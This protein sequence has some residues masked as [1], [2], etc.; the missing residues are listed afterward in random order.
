MVLRPGRRTPIWNRSTATSTCPQGSSRVRFISWCTPLRA[1]WIVGLGFAAM[2]D[3]V[4]FLKHAP[5]PFDGR[6]GNPCADAIDYAYAMGRSQSGRFLRQYIHVGINEDEESRPALDGI[7]PTWP[8]GCGASSI[9]ASGNLPRMF[10]TSS[11]RC[12]PLPTPPQSDPVTG[13]P[14]FPA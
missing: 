1:A 12:S 8:A 9:C 10:A 14:G 2:R 5:A 4:S 3:V 7:I 6:R 11:R 13:R